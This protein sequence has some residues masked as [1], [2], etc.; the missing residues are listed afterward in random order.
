MKE[1]SLTMVNSKTKTVLGRLGIADLK[2]YMGM[3][4]K[5]MVLEGSQRDLY[6]I[7]TTNHPY[8]LTE[9]QESYEQ[10]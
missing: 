3:S 9:E 8:T 10:F 7:D 2:L 5:R 6:Y 4:Q 1:I